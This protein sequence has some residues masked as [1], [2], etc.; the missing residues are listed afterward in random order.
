M[1]EQQ[2]LDA[3]REV[4][5]PGKGEQNIVDLGL[6]ERIETGEGSVTVTLAF[7]KGPTRSR[8]TLRA[9]PGQLS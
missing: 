5:H 9:P 4:T 1:T 3:L 8:I 7:P 2:I 6:V